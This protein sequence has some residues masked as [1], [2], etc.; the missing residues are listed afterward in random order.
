MM[1]TWTI[2]SALSHLRAFV[3]GPTVRAV[4]QEDIQSFVVTTDLGR[5][6]RAE[7]QQRLSSIAPAPVPAEAIA[8]SGV[9]P[10]VGTAAVQEVEEVE[11]ME[12]SGPECESPSRDIPPADQEPAF[13]P[14]LLSVPVLAGSDSSSP[15]LRSLP[16]NWLPII[17]GD[18]TVPVVRSQPYSDAYL[19]GQPSKR[20]KLNAES[21]PRGDVGQLLHQ[22]LQEVGGVT[23]LTITK[24]LHLYAH[25]FQAVDQTG[26][27]PAGGVQA[28]AETVAA[29]S[30]VQDSVEQML[31][32]TIQVSFS[33][34]LDR[35]KAFNFH[36]SG[37]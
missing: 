8:E 24:P 36:V 34:M 7:R 23:D 22:S 18:Q 10:A 4:S 20:R 37:S 28:L 6:R 9:D 3:E 35:D 2:T 17:S 21:K 27:Q 31:T 30:A 5:Q 14:S 11:E 29:N 25:Y 33:G 19:S 26:L 12:V 1:R 16:P 32:N 13:P 15:D